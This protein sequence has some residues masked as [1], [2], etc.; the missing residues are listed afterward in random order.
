MVRNRNMS[1]LVSCACG[2]SY[3]IKEQF[4][5]QKVQC[6]GCKRVLTVP[7]APAPATV[8]AGRTTAA[9]TTRKSAVRPA[10]DDEIVDLPLNDDNEILDVVA[11]ADD[12]YDDYAPRR[13]GNGLLIGILVGV[14]VLLLGGGGLAIWYF[15]RDDDTT[16]ASGSGSEKDKDKD[17]D[18]D[19]DKDKGTKDR[20]EKDKGTKD[21]G[22]KDR[23][24]KDRDRI[25]DSDGDP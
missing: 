14:F 19:G 3:P 12:D 18:K 6:P 17:K 8:T 21:N 23:G 11:P 4:A 25:K 22:S 20:G 2:K 16:V 24:G 5:G 1:I 7:G 15:T 9:A 10:P 13:K